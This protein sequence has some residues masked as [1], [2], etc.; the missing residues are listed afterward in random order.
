MQIHLASPIVSLIPFSTSSSFSVC[1]GKTS[2]L[3]FVLLVLNGIDWMVVLF[4]WI[5]YLF[6]H[7]CRNTHNHHCHSCTLDMC[8]IISWNFIQNFS[9]FLSNSTTFPLFFIYHSLT[10]KDNYTFHFLVFSRNSLWIFVLT[11]CFTFSF[12]SN[13][14]LILY[15][16]VVFSIS[17]MC[18]TCI[19]CV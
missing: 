18:G 13:N 5:V 17:V 16:F 3:F 4:L 11:L 19:P 6:L 2:L 10:L 8:N 12:S 15:F 1:H 7:I 14:I 9:F